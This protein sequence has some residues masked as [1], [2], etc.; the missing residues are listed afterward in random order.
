M[1]SAFSHAA[2]ALALGSVF[3]WDKP[4]SKYWFAGVGCAILPDAD[5]IGFAFGVRYGDLFGHRGF[6]HSL[7]FAFLL[8][9]TVTAVF[10]RAE[11]RA[12]LGPRI[13][14]Y[15]FLAT[16]SHG[17][18]DALTNGG[19]GVAFFSPFDPARYFF[20]FR[21]VEV[22]PINV[23]RFLDGRGLG[24]ILSETRWILAPALALAL[25]AEGARLVRGAGTEGKAS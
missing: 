22:S 25:A 20:S 14:A 24:V 23:A 6:T 2:A 9:L 8:A 15:L 21:P 19:L 4:A 12:G 1:A 11:A 16:A 7:C 5:S 18:L 10:F 17:L 13:L 3:R